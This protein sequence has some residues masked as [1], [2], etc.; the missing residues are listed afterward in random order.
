MGKAPAPDEHLSRAERASMLP[1]FMA[2]GAPTSQNEQWA[3]M[4]NDP[5]LAIKQQ[6]QEALKRVRHNPI[7]MQQIM[8]EV[9][10]WFGDKARAGSRSCKCVVGVFGMLQEALR[11]NL[12]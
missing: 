9:R 5:L 4:T 12:Q 11:C 3:R 8:K 1:S 2:A 6:E 10:W 7:K